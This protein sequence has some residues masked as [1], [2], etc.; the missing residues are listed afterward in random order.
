MSIRRVSGAAF[1]AMS[2]ILPLAPAGAQDSRALLERIER[3]QR[4]VDVLQRR[5]ATG[6]TGSVAPSGAVSSAP[7]GR[8]AEASWARPNSVSR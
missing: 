2:L 6:A 8:P 7:L 1:L 3:L 5:V 4:D